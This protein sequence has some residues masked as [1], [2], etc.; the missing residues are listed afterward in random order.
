[1]EL[2][3]QQFIRL[4][5]I[6]LNFL[7]VE[8]RVKFLERIIWG[9]RRL[10]IKTPLVDRW[11]ISQLL[12]PMLFAIGAFTT[13]SLSVGI[14]FDLVRK[15]VEFGLPFQI[16]LKVMILKL[17][18]FLVLS[19]PMSM[20]LATLLAYGK[21]S[22]NSEL[23]ALRSLGYTNKRIIVPVV[24]LSLLMTFITFNFNDSLVPI[25]NRVAE[26]IMRSSLGKAISSEEG[27]HIMF[28]RY[29]SQIDSSNKISES[30]ENLTH[31]FYAKFFRNN[32]MEEVTLIDYSRIGIEQTLR[33]KK[34]EFDQNNNLWIFYDGRLT[35]TQDDGTV[36]FVNFN[37]YQYPLGEGPRDLAKVPSDSNDMTLK[38]AKKA[39]ALYQKSGN[40]KEARRMSVRIQEKFTLP[41]ACL[42]FGLIGSGFGLRSISRSSKSQGFGLSVLLIFGYYLISFFSS[43]LGVK[44]VLTPFV[45]AWAPVFI[46]IAIAL[47][48]IKRASKI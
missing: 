48:L 23:L 41:A 4:E 28:S 31:I 9:F 17:P 15:I 5:K 24:F 3:S 46:S 10:I 19:F 16:A 39:E 25:S 6:N 1:M 38:Q 8:S 11:L 26:N 12:P 14:M 37:R 44:G 29:G 2:F 40:I 22:S 42:V 21:L 34:G 43:S 32:F 20:L 47:L 36:S 30:N 27:K 45:A 35:I 13:V 18:G 33:A 7:N